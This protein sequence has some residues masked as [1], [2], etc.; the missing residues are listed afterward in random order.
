MNAHIS[1]AMQNYLTPLKNQAGTEIEEAVDQPLYHLQAYATA[2]STQFT[3]FN[4]AAGGYSVT[5]MDAQ[6]VLSKGKRFAIFGIGIGYIG[7]QAIV[8]DTATTVLNSYLNDA[9]K[10]LE[11]V[12]WAELNILDK[13]Y[14]REAPLTRLPGGVGLNVGGASFQRTQTSAA[15]GTRQ[16]SYGSNGLPMLSCMRKL[17]VPIPL[18]EQT[19][20]AV[21]VNFPTAVTVTTAGTL[22]VWLDGVLLRAVQ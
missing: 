5:N 13:N 6:S 7:G 22:A 1:P 9:Q 11:G 18:P 12:A 15:D 4:T 19:K 16:I 20:F 2:G 10:V 8:Q 17:R 21:V 14:L 3:F